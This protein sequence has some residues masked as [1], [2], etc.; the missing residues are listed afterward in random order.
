MA[1]SPN[2]N[3][4]I[5]GAKFRPQRGKSLARWHAEGT[6]PDEAAAVHSRS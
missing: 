6:M 3:R 5:E 4:Q 2:A 1:P